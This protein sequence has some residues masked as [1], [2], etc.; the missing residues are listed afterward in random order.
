MITG[1]IDARE[2]VVRATELERRQIPF[3]LVQTTNDAMFDVRQA[4]RD[5]MLNVFDNPTRWTLQGILYRR[6]TLQDPAAEVFLRNELG[7]AIPPAKYLQF[8]VRGGQRAAKRSEILL[9]QAGVLAGNEFI[10]P[11][12]G[13]P[14][15]PF[16]N[17][18]GSIV[19]T[20]LSDLQ[21][22]FDPLQRST[23][24]SRARRSRRR[25]FGRRGVFFYQAGQRGKLPRGIYER[26]RSTFGTS[27]RGVFM[28]V[29]QATYEPIYDVFTVARRVYVESFRRRWQDNLNRAVAGIRRTFGR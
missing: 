17:V 12:R 14:I 1:A 20:V 16:G 11:A 23:R 26:R 5:E 24:Q 8:Q 25:S 28:I 19:Q 27:L 29:Q 2:L 4:W 18:P 13:G 22:S 21:A 10:V 15:D 6:A 7:D 9:R 3:A